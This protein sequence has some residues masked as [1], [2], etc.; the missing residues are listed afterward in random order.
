MKIFQVDSNIKW[1]DTIPEKI[2]TIYM[3][4]LLNN[5][6]FNEI[7]NKYK[8]K[9]FK[10]VLASSTHVGVWGWNSWCGIHTFPILIG[11]DVAEI[12]KNTVQVGFDRCEDKT[13]LLPH[14]IIHRNGIFGSEITHMCYGG[15]NGE[16]YNFCNILCW[17]KMAM[18]Y[19][20]ISGDR[21]WFTD[22]IITTITKTLDY[23][24]NNYRDKFNP[25]LVYA[26]V[27]GC[28]TECTDWVLDNANV[29]VNMLNALQLVIECQKLLK[30][31]YSSLDYQA[32]YIEIKSNFN[33]PLNEGG[34]WQEITENGTIC[35]FYGHGNNGKGSE[36]HGDKY[37]ESTTNYFALLWGIVDDDKRDKLWKYIN[38]HQDELEKPYPVLTNLYPR[39]GA[40]RKNYG[41]TVTNGD[42][43]MVL[44]AHAAAARLQDNFIKIGTEMYQTIVNYEKEHGVLHNCIY[45]NGR[46][47]DSW[48]PEV[49]NYGALFAPFAL[50]ILGI[51]PK[52]NGIEFNIKPLTD[53]TNISTKLYVFG[54]PIEVS[55][56]WK[57]GN[58]ISVRIQDITT[59]SEVI[60]KVAHFKLLRT[61]QLEIEELK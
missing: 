39:T 36:V 11:E 10:R 20:L 54:K 33:K 37:F 55:I 25:K 3:G 4:K 6:V 21:E 29:N 18:E 45:Q 32:I 60:S 42:I 38:L 2:R 28:W 61:E 44:G 5:N 59:K 40:R 13:G 56:Q 8:R 41:N 58:L 1:I 31:K 35:G 23:I 51:V 43:W 47:N 14:A 52:A 24:L 34:F 49:A 7:H 27:E 16:S 50:G 30:K 19:Y 46:V 26:G 48:D 57:N 12:Y 9:F 22:K 53:L 17:A 15:A